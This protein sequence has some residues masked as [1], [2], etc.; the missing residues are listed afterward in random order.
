MQSFILKN[1]PY[2]VDGSVKWYN[3]FE[4]KVW[5]FLKKLNI[6]LKPALSS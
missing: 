2:T 3:Y 6:I 5:Q 1:N 4:K